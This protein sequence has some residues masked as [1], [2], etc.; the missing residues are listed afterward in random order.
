MQA[1]ILPIRWHV[2][3][4]NERSNRR[5]RWK[6]HE[7][8][9]RRQEGGEKLGG[10]KAKLSLKKTSQA[11]TG[12]RTKRTRMEEVEDRKWETE[13]VF[14]SAS[15]LITLSCWSGCFRASTLNV[16]FSRPQSRNPLIRVDFST[17]KS[18]ATVCRE[19]VWR[20]SASPARG[21]KPGGAVEAAGQIEADARWCTVGSNEKKVKASTPKRCRAAFLGD[22]PLRVSLHLK[23]Y[24]LRGRKTHK[25]S[26]LSLPRSSTEVYVKSMKGCREGVKDSIVW[27]LTSPRRSSLKSCD[28]RDET[29]GQIW[30][31]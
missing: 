17:A 20:S 28:M 27:L 26:L 12:K 3:E 8:Q 10:D 7:R 31:N 11:E 16:L 24:Y 5:G 21:T 30:S 1:A 2:D 14:K 22:S 15:C 4:K 13:P 6:E 29:T 23:P 25:S 19:T 18:Q 9:K